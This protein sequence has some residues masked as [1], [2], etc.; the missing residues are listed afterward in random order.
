MSDVHTPSQRSRNMAAIK[1]ANTKPEM[2][3][4][5]ALHALGYRFRLHRKQ[6]PG[7]PDIVLPRHRVVI[8][9]HGCFW[10]SHSCRWG[11][12]KPKTRADF[13]S[14]KRGGTVERDARNRA[15]LAEL[16]WRVLTVWECETRNP[17][18][19]RETLI[20]RL[21]HENGTDDRAEL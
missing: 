9:V 16:G 5:S 10:H 14:D 11:A 1:G 4:R 19:L 18:E 7:R 12:V 20:G 13:W 15:Q 17:A 21:R 3:V 8:F 6:L 2:R